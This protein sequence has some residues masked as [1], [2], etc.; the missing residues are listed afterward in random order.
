MKELFNRWLAEHTHIPGVLAAGVR[1]PDQTSVMQ[2][3]SP[4]FT[5]Q[6]LENALRCM[7][8]AFQVLRINFFANERVRWVYENAYLYAA[9]RDDNIFLGIFTTKG[10]QSFDPGAIDQLIMEFLALSSP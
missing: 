9:R 1:F 5:T 6:A 2:A 8:D 7:S 3:W 4:R 10:S